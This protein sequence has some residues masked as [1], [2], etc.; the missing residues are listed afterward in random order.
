MDIQ[1]YQNKRIFKSYNIPVLKGRVAYTPDEAVEIANQI[2]GKSW[3][4]KVQINNASHLDG[5]FQDGVLKQKKGI[6]TAKSLD[7]VRQM[8][9]NM[10]GHVFVRP[11]THCQEQVVHRI[12]V[13]ETAKIHRSFGVSVRLDL[14]RQT[15][16]FTVSCADKV[17]EFEIAHM[18]PTLLFWYRVVHAFRV[19]G[20]AQTTL[21]AIL[22]QMYKLFLAYDALGVEIN[23]LILTP[24]NKWVVG[25][26]RIVFDNEA[27]ERYPDIMALKET[28]VGQEREATA[29]KYHFKYTP[30]NGNIACL[31]NGS[32]LGA[33]TIELLE[34]HHGRAACLLDVGTEPTGDSVSRAFKLAL[35]EPNVEG[36]FINIFGGLT[37]CDTIAQGL[38]DASKEISVG[39]PL[40]VRMD[41]TNANVGERLIFES[42][43]PFTVI[44]QPEQAVMAIVNAVEESQA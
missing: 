41:G 33:A 23:P 20:L 35:S 5:F 34:M 32:G 14:M 22:R 12:Y 30:L 36:I 31:V 27:I 6:Q 11:Q 37:R 19:K 43:L 2:G 44:K 8:A 42:R 38:I 24:K 39:I 28:P 7:E 3:Q 13:E 10:L 1:E 17:Q 16:V 4:L 21:V 15:Y 9:D 29:E 25:E 40:V 26:C 18:R